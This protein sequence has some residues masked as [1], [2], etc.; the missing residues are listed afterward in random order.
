MSIHHLDGSNGIPF[1]TLMAAATLHAY[2][3]AE[4]H[5]CHA[6][7]QRLADLT[8][9]EALALREERGWNLDVPWTG[10]TGDGDLDARLAE[11]F[12]ALLARRS[13]DERL[14]FIEAEVWS[15]QMFPHP[16]APVDLYRETLM[17]W[18]LDLF[19]GSAPR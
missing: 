12:R 2:R 5:A 10:T 8:I 17:R 6:C 19:E 14:R 1:E 16:A 3:S 7:G 9:G 13:L 4:M 18:W 11:A 15:P